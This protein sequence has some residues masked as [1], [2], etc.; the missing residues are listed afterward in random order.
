MT[1]FSTR[2]STFP[3]NCVPGE[4]EF[5]KQKVSA[6][7]PSTSSGAYGMRK[8]PPRA[9][10]PSRRPIMEV[11]GIPQKVVKYGSKKK[12]IKGCK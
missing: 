11:S 12:L 1:V 9:F 8:E 3:K 4:L 2:F 6:S 7:D 5:S 10:G